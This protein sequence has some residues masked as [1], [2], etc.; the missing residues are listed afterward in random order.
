MHERLKYLADLLLNI[1]YIEVREIHVKIYTNSA[2]G[3]LK[4]I[5][6]P[7][8][9]K[10]SHINSFEIIQIREESLVNS[11]GQFEPHLL[12]WAHKDSLR[13]DYM[14]S[15]EN[16]YFL[17]LEDDAIFTQSNLYYFITHR[18]RLRSLGLI[19]SFLRIEWSQI[20]FDWISTDSFERLPNELDSKWFTH[21]GSPYMEVENPYCAL[22]LLDRELA[23]EYLSSE[24][25]KIE[26]ARLKHNFIWDTAATSA[27]GLIAEAV[28]EGFSSRTVIG[29]GTDSKLPLIGSIVRHQGDR[30][31]NEI[32]WRHFRA[33]DDPSKS[34]L[35]IPKRTIHKK[36]KRILKEPKVLIQ[37]FRFKVVSRYFNW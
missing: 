5:S 4:N 25:A 20:H 37:Y 22:I 7:I 11:T 26:T 36:I 19:P 6:G 23:E 17:Y 14:S 16:S 32:W 35:P 24:S 3:E 31:A 12:T 10:N 33:F 2:L 29:L 1:A 13:A 28:P 18:E 9:A 21:E 15:K 8:K 34:S 30:Y 27:L